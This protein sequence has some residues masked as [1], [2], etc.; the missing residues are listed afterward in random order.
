VYIHFSKYKRGEIIN[1]SGT[2]GS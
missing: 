2:Y 1:V